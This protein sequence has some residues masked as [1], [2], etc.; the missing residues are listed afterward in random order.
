MVQQILHDRAIRWSF[1]QQ[2]RQPLLIQGLRDSSPDRGVHAL[3][4]T[5]A[6]RME[7]RERPI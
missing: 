2:G 4:A 6:S 5:S 3:M 7:K 1:E